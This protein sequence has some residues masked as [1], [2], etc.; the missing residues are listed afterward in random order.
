MQN[1]TPSRPPPPTTNRRIV[2]TARG[3]PGV[4]RLVEE[5]VPEPQA[6][7]VRVRVLVAGVL[8]GDVFWQQGLIPGSPKPPFTPGYDVIGVVDRVGAGVEAVQVGDRVA[9]L[10]EFGGYSAYVIVATTKLAVVPTDIDPVH[11]SALVMNYLTAYQIL[12]H[13]ADVHA[14][15]TMLVHGAAGATGTAFLDL[16]CMIGLEMWGT[17]SQAKHDIVAH[18]GARPI[19]YRSEDVVTWMQ[20]AAPRG[21]DLVIDPIGGPHLDR[22]WQLVR[23]NGRLVAT[24]ALSALHGA[25]SL[26]TVTGF[27][28]L[29]LRNVVP[30][31]RSAM[32]FNVVTFNRRRPA[33]FARD[34]RTLID[35]YQ[36]G[37]IAPRIGAVVPLEE[38]ARAQH[39][40]IDSQARGRVVL[41]CAAR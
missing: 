34:L 20:R 11:L 31:G 8:L 4:L 36:A 27:A 40:L 2:A 25:S 39:L 38:A 7:E 32:L 24:A 41:Q 12:R 3:G 9:A 21:V 26:S 33:A 18:Y 16:G 5:A 6:D 15:T 30:N 22:S 13:V 29:W 14:G 23:R 10:T 28:K 37:Q 35:Y 19:D 17:A 1:S